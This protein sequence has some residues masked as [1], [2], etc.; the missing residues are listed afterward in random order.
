MVAIG[1]RNAVIES[2]EVPLSQVLCDLEVIERI[3]LKQMHQVKKVKVGYQTLGEPSAAKQQADQVK[4]KRY[5]PN[6]AAPSDAS[7]HVNPIESPRHLRPRQDSH[8]P[9][10]LRKCQRPLLG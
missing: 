6:H 10:S 1:E 8:S 9:A 5:L 3:I 4:S 7:N 2:R